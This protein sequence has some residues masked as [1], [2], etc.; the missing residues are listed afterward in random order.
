MTTSFIRI[1]PP[2][3]HTKY[4]PLYHHQNLLQSTSLSLP[5]VSSLQPII[6]PPFVLPTSIEECIDW[7]DHYCDQTFLH[8]VIASDYHFLYRGI[9]TTTTP[10][11]TINPTSIIP[12]KSTIATTTTKT[13]LRPLQP[14]IQ[15]D[16]PD[17]LLI[18]TYGMDGAQFFQR[19]EDILHNETIRPS[20]GHLGTTI[21]TEAA[22]W[23]NYS[24]SIWP[25]NVLLCYH[26]DSIT[27]SIRIHN[28]YAWFDTGGLFYPRP[29]INNRSR[30]DDI[31][32]SIRI[33]TT[34][35]GSECDDHN[36]D[37]NDDDM[38]DNLIDA[39]QYKDGCEIMF[40][41]NTYLAIPSIYDVAIRDQLRRSF[42]I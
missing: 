1:V 9:S 5:S 41:T 14:T 6:N 10:T 11:T 30:N 36:D 29:N 27:T 37:P 18:E 23:G 17:L 24:A 28:S 31:R 7:I 21:P 19:I 15:N 40:T 34:D 39:L 33:V 42:L 22:I 20:I 8:A 16:I 2:P 4:F 3:Y 25:S 12:V 32:R 35:V 26:N 13:S 38:I